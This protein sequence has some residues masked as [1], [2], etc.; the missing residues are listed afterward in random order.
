MAP[1]HRAVLATVLFHRR[2]A[3]DAALQELSDSCLSALAIILSSDVQWSE[4]PQFLLR[5]AEY[6]AKRRICFGVVQIS[7]ENRNAYA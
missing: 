2:V 6:G 4:L 3:I 7:I 5:V 1:Y